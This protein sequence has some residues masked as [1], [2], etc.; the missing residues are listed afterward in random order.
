MGE[1]PSDV[2]ADDH[3][4]GRRVGLGGRARGVGRLVQEDQEDLL[5]PFY[6]QPGM[7]G[8]GGEGLGDR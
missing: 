1:R 5:L 7:Y 3:R 4:R 2:A 8:F 6:L